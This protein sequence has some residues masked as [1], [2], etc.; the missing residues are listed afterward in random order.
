MNPTNFNKSLNHFS[1]FINLKVY[2]Q[3]SF[4][5]LDLSYFKVWTRNTTNCLYIFLEETSFPSL[6]PVL[7]RSMRSP[8]GRSSVQVVSKIM[9]TK[10]NAII[11]NK[12]HTHTQHTHTHKGRHRQV[13]QYLHHFVSLFFPIVVVVV[14]AVVSFGHTL[15]HN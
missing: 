3:T 5:H 1:H 4:H 13:Q 7:L 8:C 2:P 12:Q 11:N 14:V 15:G 6:P 9:Q 10:V